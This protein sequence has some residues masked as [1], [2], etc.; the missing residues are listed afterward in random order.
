MPDPVVAAAAE[1][2]SAPVQA[3]PTHWRVLVVD[4]NPVN[5]MVVQAM[6]SSLGLASDAAGDGL[7]ALQVVPQNGPYDLLLMDMLMP[8]IDGLETTRRLRAMELPAQP[9]IAA[10][11][12]NALDE[13]RAQCLAA[14]MD[15]FLSKPLKTEELAACL[16]RLA[17]REERP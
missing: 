9:F 11:T 17:A 12:A 15:D 1:S 2:P 16:R 13:D 3:L 8:E 6:L 14:G 7:T 4:D 10:L 5:T